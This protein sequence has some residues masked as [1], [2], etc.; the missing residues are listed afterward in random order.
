[1]KL[2]SLIRSFAVFE[3]NAK[4]DLWNL[5][6]NDKN[7]WIPPKINIDSSMVEYI[8]VTAHIYI[9]IANI[10][11]PLIPNRILKNYLQ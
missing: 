5:Q 3:L 6:N 4:I 8:F 9:P 2:Y 1:M 7:I 10:I 11:I